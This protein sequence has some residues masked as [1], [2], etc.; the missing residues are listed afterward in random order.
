MHAEVATEQESEHLSKSEIRSELMSLTEADILR[1]GKIGEQYAWSCLMDADDLLSESIAVSLSGD[2]RCPRNV[3]LIVFLRQT[4]RSIAFNEK[5]KANLLYRQEPI[6]NDPENDPLL[7]F[8][9]GKA[10]I[11]ESVETYTELGA[12]FA[13]FEHD[14]DVNMLLMGLLDGYEPNEICGITGWDRKTYNTIRKRMRRGV[15]K[16]YPKGRQK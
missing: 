14:D 16:H 11:L 9:D 6:D 7:S 15:D 12:L 2:R 4:M 3:P 10:T 13:L 1:L 5:R 8:P